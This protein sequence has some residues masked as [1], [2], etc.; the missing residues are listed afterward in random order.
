MEPAASLRFAAVKTP[1][2]RSAKNGSLNG[3]CTKCPS[4]ISRSKPKR[5]KIPTPTPFPTRRFIIS[6]EFVI[7]R[8]DAATL[9]DLRAVVRCGHSGPRSDHR[10]SG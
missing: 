5:E 1:I 10:T 3:T 2:F 9:W 4:A 6:R 8:G 7:A